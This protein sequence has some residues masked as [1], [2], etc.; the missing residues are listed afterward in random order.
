MTEKDV[1]ITSVGQFIGSAPAALAASGLNL[2][3][4]RTNDL[5]R[6]DEWEELDT[7]VV[8]VFTKRL[9]GI[10]DLRDAGLTLRLGGLGTLV[11]QYEQQSDMTAADVDMSGATPGERDLPAFN[12]VGVPV[13]IIHKDFQINIRHLEASRKLG[14]SLDM[15]AAEIAARK[16][17]EALEDILFNGSSVVVDGSSIYGYTNESNINSDTASNWGGGDFGTLGNIL[18]TYL[19]MLGALEGDYAYGPYGSYVATTQYRQMLDVYDDGSGQSARERVLQAIPELQFIKPSADL[20][21]GTVLIVQMTR[22]VVDLA[23]GADVTTVQWA[24]QGGMVQNFKV[25]TAAVPR[26]KSDYAGQSGIA[27]ATSA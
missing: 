12:L 1:K 13:P 3:A 7:R 2:N 16:V 17:A 11:S 23:I 24:T 8:E 25:M 19:G 10:Q 6:K 20:A 15:T 18:P 22:D 5:L 9:R 14:D 4:L 21:D 26:V 27:E